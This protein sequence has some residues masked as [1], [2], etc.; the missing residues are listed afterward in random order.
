MSNGY[1]FANGYFALRIP[2][3]FAHMVMLSCELEIS[4]MT[5]GTVL[6][7]SF[8]QIVVDHPYV[9]TSHL[10]CC[11]TQECLKVERVHAGS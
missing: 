11:V 7:V 2:G 5:D 9:P 6:P 1:V 3:R 10:Q 8:H 4:Y